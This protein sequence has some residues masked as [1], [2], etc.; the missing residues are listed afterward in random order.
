MVGQSSSPTM[1]WW[2]LRKA[3]SEGEGDGDGIID[4]SE[5]LGTQVQI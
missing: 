2:G 3:Q 1:V 5:N 4:F